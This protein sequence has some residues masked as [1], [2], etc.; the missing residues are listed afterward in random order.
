MGRLPLPVLYGERAGVRGLVIGR[1]GQSPSP[2]SCPSPRK[3]RGEGTRTHVRAITVTSP[4]EALPPS[5]PL[6]DKLAQSAQ[7]WSAEGRVRGVSLSPSFTG[8]GPGRGATP[9]PRPLRGKGQGEGPGDRARR[10]VPLPL[11]LS[12]SPSRTGRRDA[13]ACRRHH[14][15]LATRGSSPLPPACG[16]ACAIRTSLERGREG[17]GGGRLPLP[18]LYGERAGVRGLVIG[19]G[20]Q[21]PRPSSCPSPRKERG[22]GTLCTHGAHPEAQRSGA[23]EPRKPHN[24]KAASSTA[25]PSCR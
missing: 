12:F 23:K 17:G 13:H 4:P 25:R 9:S 24:A 7:V 21:S 3:E 16:Q 22:E 19:R 11:I 14:G 15:D 2:S 6:A 8:R 20:G 1:G 10:A 5:P 18:V